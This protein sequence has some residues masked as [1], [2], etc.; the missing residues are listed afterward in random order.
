MLV[1]LSSPAVGQDGAEQDAPASGSVTVL[2]DVPYGTALHRYSSGQTLDVK[3]GPE[4]TVLSALA[5][6]LKPLT[7]A[8]QASVFGSNLGQVAGQ[9]QSGIGALGHIENAVGSG[10]SLQHGEGGGGAVG[11][12]LSQMPSVGGIL[13]G[14]LGDGQ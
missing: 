12:A 13:R 14:A 11:S 6:G 3:T 4:E 7:D 8:Q 10:L 1:S 9:T 2:R 5:Q